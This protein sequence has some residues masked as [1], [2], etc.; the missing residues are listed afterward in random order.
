LVLLAL[1]LSG[2][3]TYLGTAPT[4]SIEEEKPVSNQQAA[5][6]QGS[7]P[8]PVTRVSHE[9]PREKLLS[10]LQDSIQPVSI[11]IAVVVVMLMGHE[12]RYNTI[13]Y[14]LTSSNRRSKV[15]ASKVLVSGTFTIVVT[16]LALA[17]V[18]VATYAAISVKGL[19]LPDQNFFDWPYILARLFGYAL[20]FSLIGLALIT[21]VRSLTAG[22]V[23]LFLLPTLDAIAGELLKNWDIA[24]TKVLPF[25]ALNRLVNIVQDYI[26]LPPG[27]D[28]GQS[29]SQATV[30]GAAAVFALYFVGIWIAAWYLFLR[31]DAS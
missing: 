26:H 23:A 14:T 1:F 13:S 20:G 9:L 21:L 15:L 8:K 4:T 3:F 31:R 5:E 7:P 17:V 18:I 29:L 27:V 6:N 22:I 24:A 19:H 10:N 11:F 28:A 12:F 2:L 16:A 25:S 30:L